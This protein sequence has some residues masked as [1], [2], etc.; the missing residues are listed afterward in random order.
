MSSESQ[1]SGSGNA[2]TYVSWAVAIYFVPFIAVVLDELV[3]KTRWC[4]QHL[5]S[6][7]GEIFSIAYY[8]FVQLV[9]LFLH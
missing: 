4:A 7:G 5:P 2:G 1:Q 3:L 9:K 8:P 6:K